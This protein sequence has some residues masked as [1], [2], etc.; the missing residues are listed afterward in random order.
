MSYIHTCIYV[1]VF[2]SYYFE[3]LC[4]CIPYIRSPNSFPPVQ[5]P[6]YCLL[7]AAAI[8]WKH[9][10]HNSI[11]LTLYKVACAPA[12][13]TVEPLMHT[14]MNASQCAAQCMVM[15]VSS[16]QLALPFSRSTKR[17]SCSQHTLTCQYLAIYVAA[18]AGQTNGV[19]Q[20]EV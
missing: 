14:Q 18:T 1:H 8:W 16:Y 7:S 20:Y 12:D 13:Y 4:G 6:T 5:L 15:I 11:T 9:F 19:V 3:Y 10:N 17:S 2:Y